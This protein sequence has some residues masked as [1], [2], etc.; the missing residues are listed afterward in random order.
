[1]PDRGFFERMFIR[2]VVF[3]YALSLPASAVSVLVLHTPT[4]F[5]YDLW[6]WSAVVWGYGM[7]LLVRRQGWVPARHGMQ[8]LT[9]SRVV[10]VLGV[11]YVLV[12]LGG[13]I[14]AFFLPQA[15]GFSR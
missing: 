14:V 5:Q 15:F 11:L 7:Y 12:A 2:I 10:S 13:A 1:M 9:N 6:F 8:L 3:G 4:Y